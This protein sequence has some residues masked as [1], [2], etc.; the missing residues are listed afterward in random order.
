MKKILAAILLIFFFTQ[1]K[2]QTPYTA[3][4]GFNYAA[5]TAAP[6]ALGTHVRL[7]ISTGRVYQWSPDALNWQLQGYTIEQISG[8]VAP[9]YTPVRGQS[10]FVVNND[11]LPR[12]YQYTGSGTAWKCLNCSS[13]KTYTAGEGV[14]IYGNTIQLDTLDRL[15]FA[16]SPVLPGGVGTI[17]WNDTDGCLEYGMK[18]GTVVQQIG[19]EQL[20]LVKHADNTGLTLGKVVYFVGS[21]GT[22]KTVRYALANAESTSANTFGVMAEST[23]GGNK[24]FCT[25]F[26]LV[27][28]LNT[29][30]LSEGS[31]VWLSESSAGDMTTTRPT[32]PS[33]AVQ[34]G[35]CI[36]SHATQGVI[37]VSVQNGYELEELH[38]VSST[39]PTAGQVLKWDGTVWKPDTDNNTG[40]TYTAGTG[41]SISGGNVIANTLPDQTVVIT[42]ATGTYPNFTL[43]DQSATNELQNL[44]LTGQ[45][46]GISSGTGVTLPI[47]DIVAGANIT[48]TKSLGAAT[49]SAAAAGI[50]SLNGLTA[51]TQTFATGSAGTDWGI[52]SSGT[53]HTF[54]LPTA[55]ATNRGAL[56]TT[57]WNIFNGKLGGSGVN[58]Q[59]AFFTGTS[60]IAGNSGFNYSSATGSYVF[61][62]T[63]ASEHIR[64]ISNFSANGI[65]PLFNSLALA[66]ETPLT[67]AVLGSS[68]ALKWTAPGWKTASVAASQNIDFRSYVQTASGSSAPTGLLIFDSQVNGAGYSSGFNIS[69]AGNVGIGLGNVAAGNKLQVSGAAQATSFVADF[70]SA[71]AID[72]PFDLRRTAHGNS[73]PANAGLGIKFTYREAAGLWEPDKIISKVEATSG[74]IVTTSLS[75]ETHDNESV[76]AALGKAFIIYG[77]KA[78]VNVSS[79]L[80][81]FHIKGKTSDN[82]ESALLVQNSTPSDIFKIRNDGQI[83]V[84]ATNTAAGTTG[85]QTINKPSGTVNFA[86]GATSLTVTNSLCTT[87]SI[88]I[89]VIRTN[90]AT[91]TIKN[92]VPASGSFTINL[93]A[94]ATAE[95]S[96]GFLIIN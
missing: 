94:A 58:G 93:T 1:A 63:S 59:S 42:G 30:S 27:T 72:Y 74:G 33:H 4:W 3:P 65:P 15:S 6:S 28:G 14:N 48:V 87:T 57:D 60:T 19:L 71:A 92:V 13:G 83:S 82:L 66:N 50:T 23:T 29:L 73:V 76:N 88:V 46:L 45:S 84:W 10:W 67:S 51:G 44:S 18:G 35:Y 31:M 81:S 17:R 8:S 22:N 9:A 25:T 68:P 80:A 49:I 20:T 36:R 61:G 89:P 24:A 56:S 7:D 70:G 95:T 41:I 47:I 69:T 86:A 54:N 43:P 90:D 52:S 75:V 34:I 16:A 32:A 77:R 78:G 85:A 11:T 55:S 37:F 53:A 26:G 39:T 38:N 62:G 91:A 79:P 21:D 5:P 12:L 2:A 96:V 40:T 64:L